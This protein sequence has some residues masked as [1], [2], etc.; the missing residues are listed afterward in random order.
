[1]DSAPSCSMFTVE[2]SLISIAWILF[3]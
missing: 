2:I 1:M 3:H